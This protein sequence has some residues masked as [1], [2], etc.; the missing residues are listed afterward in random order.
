MGGR[1]E[2]PLRYGMINIVL[3]NN[4]LCLSKN[5]FNWTNYIQRC[6]KKNCQVGYLHAAPKKKKSWR[7]Q[8]TQSPGLHLK[9]LIFGASFV[10]LKCWLNS[11]NLFIP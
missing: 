1:G 11:G 9:E 10:A 7:E 2:N 6:E 8:L 5:K 4:G 3:A